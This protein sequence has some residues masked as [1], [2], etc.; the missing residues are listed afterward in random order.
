VL[1]L[2]LFL[3]LSIYNLLTQYVKELMTHQPSLTHLSLMSGI[4]S[5]QASITYIISSSKKN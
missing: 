5:L 2:P 4:R 1:P 3:R